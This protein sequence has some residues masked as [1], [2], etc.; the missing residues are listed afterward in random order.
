MNW[1]SPTTSTVV[2]SSHSRGPSGVLP[3]LCSGVRRI[4]LPLSRLSLLTLRSPMRAPW[5]VEWTSAYQR[6]CLVALRDAPCRVFA[7][8][9]RELRPPKSGGRVMFGRCESCLDHRSEPIT[10]ANDER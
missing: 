1:T 5:S 2:G 7:P 9:W 4:L 8:S 6:S 10:G 3:G